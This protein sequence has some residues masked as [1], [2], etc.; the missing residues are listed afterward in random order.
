MTFERRIELIQCSIMFIMFGIVVWVELS[1]SEIIAGL[2]I[3]G[4]IACLWMLHKTWDLQKQQRLAETALLERRVN[5]FQ[6]DLIHYRDTVWKER[7]LLGDQTCLYNARSRYLQCAMHP[8]GDCSQC[9]DRI[10]I[11]FSDPDDPPELP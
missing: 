5:E 2:G 11:F 3:L 7:C 1:H 9:K 6:E 4:M 8:T 10:S